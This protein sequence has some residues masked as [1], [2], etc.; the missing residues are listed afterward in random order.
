MKNKQDT[1][2]LGDKIINGIKKAVKKLF[3][4]GKLKMKKFLY[5]KMVRW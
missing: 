1:K 3:L 5:P 4:T 2:K